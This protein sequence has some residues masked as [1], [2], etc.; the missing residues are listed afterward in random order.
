MRYLC[1]NSFLF[2]R[3]CALA[4]MA[5]IYQSLRRVLQVEK[6]SKILSNMSH[7]LPSGSLRDTVRLSTAAALEAF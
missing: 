3:T 1:A 2:S 5:R 7:S 6:T 4:L